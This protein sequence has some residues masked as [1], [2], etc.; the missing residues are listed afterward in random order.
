MTL[1]FAI[2]K[3]WVILF[4]WEM[5]SQEWGLEMGPCES[6]THAYPASLVTNC[7]QMWINW[8]KLGMQAATRENISLFKANQHRR[9]PNP[10]PWAS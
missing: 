9:G 7:T 3:L 2:C 4:C 1:N 8:P 5:L 6:F 10:Q